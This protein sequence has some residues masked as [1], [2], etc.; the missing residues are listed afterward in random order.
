MSMNEYKN[1]NWVRMLGTCPEGKGLIHVLLF[2]GDTRPG[3]MGKKE[4]DP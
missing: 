4:M 2:L 1:P 3:E